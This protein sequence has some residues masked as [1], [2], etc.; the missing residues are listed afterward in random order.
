MVDDAAAAAYRRYQE[1]EY[2]RRIL[3]QIKETPSNIMRIRTL[4]EARDRWRAADGTSEGIT[5]RIDRRMANACSSTTPS[6]NR[7]RREEVEAMRGQST[8]P[9]IKRWMRNGVNRC[10]AVARAAATAQQ[11]SRMSSVPRTLAGRHGS[12]PRAATSFC[13]TCLKAAFCKVTC[14]HVSRGLPSVCDRAGLGRRG[15]ANAASRPDAFAPRRQRLPRVLAAGIVAKGSL[16]AIKG[17]ERAHR[18]TTRSISTLAADGP[19]R[20]GEVTCPAEEA[21][22]P[23]ALARGGA[24]LRGSPGATSVV[25][26]NFFLVV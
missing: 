14:P 3:Q 4:E 24:V 25:D 16:R 12:R 11:R 15:E 17:L 6:L 9:P 26:D 21:E 8:A 13:E 23:P 19:M 18:E 5:E 22:R 7:I 2:E 10:R 1:E 20:R